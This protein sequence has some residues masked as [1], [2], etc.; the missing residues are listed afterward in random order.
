MLYSFEDFVLDTNKQELRCGDT[1]VRLQAK[2][3]DLL[4]FLIRS[5]GRLVSKDELVATVWKGTIVSESAMSSCLADARKAIGDTSK[6]KHLIKTFPTKGFRFVGAV[7]ETHV[8]ASPGRRQVEDALMTSANRKQALEAGNPQDDSRLDKSRAEDSVPV[9][10]TSLIAVRLPPLPPLLVGREV[11]LT[12]LKARIVVKPAILQPRVTVVRGWPG[13]GKT[14][15]VNTLANDKDVMSAFPDGVLWA[16][17][18][19]SPNLLGELAAWSR[20]LGAPFA[21]SHPEIADLTFEV[22]KRLHDRQVLLILDD[23]WE[24]SA[25]IPFKVASARCATLITTRDTELARN[26]ATTSNDVYVL[27][28][29]DEVR[30]LELL[31]HVAPSFTNAHFPEARQL[32]FDLDGLPLALRVAGGLLEEETRLRWSGVQDLLAELTETTRLLS[33]V[34]PED[35]YDSRTGTFPTVSLLLQRSTER[36]DAETR[37]RFTSLGSFAA[38]P[39]TFDLDAMHHQWG[40]ADVKESK[41]TVRKL[42]NRGLLEPSPSPDEARF[43]MH[44]LLVLHARSLADQASSEVLKSA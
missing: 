36:L 31:K 23:V 18:G 10:R 14:S 11:D 43:Q 24:M 13:V 21:G 7:V 44:A 3:Y 32:V 37:G 27:D 28:K 16:A 19:E 40:S 20:A 35:R 6:S 2:T 4:E 41:E 29:F 38:K 12:E 22:R 5:R 25:V 8:P 15:L 34:A 26:I 17:F 1:P 9:E 39:A 33:E 42:V 30:G